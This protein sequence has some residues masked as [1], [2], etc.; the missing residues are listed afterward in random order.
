MKKKIRIG[1]AEIDFNRGIFSATLPY[2]VSAFE[3][4]AITNMSL[5]RL[6][7]NARISGCCR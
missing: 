3:T 7:K 6:K 2:Q 5:K 4:T 1:D